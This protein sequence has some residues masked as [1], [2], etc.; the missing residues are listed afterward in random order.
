MKKILFALILILSCGFTATAEEVSFTVA[1]PRVVSTNETF[2]VTFSVNE[3]TDDFTGPEL[4]GFHVLAGPTTSTSQSFQVVNGKASHSQ[5]TNYTYVLQ[6]TKEGKVTLGAASVVVDGKTY[7]TQPQVIEVLKADD[8]AAAQQSNRTN[9]GQSQAAASAAGGDMFVRVQLSKSNVYRGEY[10]I[11]TIKLYAQNTNFAGFEDIKFPV[12]NGFWSQ[13]LESPQQ[14]NFQRENVNGKIYNAALIRRY[15]LF[16]QQTGE[17]KI[18]PFEI[19]CGVVVQTSRNIFDSFFS[20][21][22]VSRKRLVSP[23]GT[24]Q[25][26]ALPGQA[27]VSFAGAVG[28]NFKMT[29]ELTR[30]SVTANDALSLMI[31]VNGEGNVKLVDAPKVQFPPDFEA[32]DMKTTDNS[33][34]SSTGVSGAKQ[35]EI[36]FIPR[37][38]GSFTIAPVEFTYFDIAKKE[39]ITITSK[40]LPIKVEK[41]PNAGSSITVASGNRQLVKSLG[42]DIRYI[43]TDIPAWHQ[44][45]KVFFGT[46]GYYLLLGLEI[47]LFIAIYGFLRERR[48]TAQNVALV[49]NRQ[50]NKAA[51][52]RLKTAG[53]LLRAGLQTGFYEELSKALWGYL[54]D[55]LA[56]AVADLSRGNMKEAL[57]SHGIDEGEA[58]AFLQVVD[59]CEFARYAPSGGQLQMEKIYDDAMTAISRFEQLLK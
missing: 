51:R 6:A 30:D 27:P 25:V 49:R 1:A 20:S 17:V 18:E 9:S 10:L 57:M 43:K 58:E 55:K 50:A 48:K 53:Q 44:K 19:T 24:V 42:E 8:A 34:T 38:A 7:H 5:S 29:A 52:K 15:I 12:F 36:P 37:S 46:W 40:P 2:R 26:K 13:E 33:K 41:D 59:E 47:V 35:F 16:P 45:G 32:Y 28:T 31:K 39:Y 4:A 22:Q 21:P 3:R 23:E 14:L 54:S 56:I 11:A